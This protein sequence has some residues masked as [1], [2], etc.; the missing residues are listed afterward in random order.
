MS[1]DAAILLISI[2]GIVYFIAVIFF[3]AYGSGKRGKR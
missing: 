2:M 1:A 3:A